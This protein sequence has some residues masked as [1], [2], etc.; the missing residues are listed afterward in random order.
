MGYIAL[1]MATSNRPTFTLPIKAATQKNPAATWGMW[2]GVVSVFLPLGLLPIL[3]IVVSGV[4]L[5]RAKERG[6]KGKALAGL[7]LGC[8]FT[9][10]YLR[11]Y[12]YLGSL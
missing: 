8:L 4:G 6:G 9:L 3:A 1:R 11:N 7:I 12:G 5:D 10:V 2:L